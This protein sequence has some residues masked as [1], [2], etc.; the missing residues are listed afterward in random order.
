MPIIE[1]ANFVFTTSFKISFQKQQIKFAVS[2]KIFM[3][4]RV[5]IC[6]DNINKLTRKLQL[7]PIFR[8]HHEKIWSNKFCLDGIV[9]NKSQVT[10]LF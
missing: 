5:K 2:R 6:L 9:N 4:V 1:E 7:S 3:N 10:H 8:Q